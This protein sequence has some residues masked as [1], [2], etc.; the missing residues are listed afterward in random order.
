MEHVDLYL[1]HPLPGE[2]GAAAEG[3]RRTRRRR[4]RVGAGEAGPGG[5]GHA[6]RVGGDGG[7]PAARPRQSHRHLGLV[8]FELCVI[9]GVRPVVVESMACCHDMTVLVL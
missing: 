5:A 9:L 7:V 4:R 8:Y 6:G 2:H 1:P 3:S